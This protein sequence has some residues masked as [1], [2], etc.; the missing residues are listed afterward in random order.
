[1]WRWFIAHVISIV[2]ALLITWKLYAEWQLNDFNVFLLLFVLIGGVPI[3]VTGH[4]I[5]SS[6]YR[7]NDDS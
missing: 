5:W 1:M 7:S 6:E 4:M 3:F 2:I